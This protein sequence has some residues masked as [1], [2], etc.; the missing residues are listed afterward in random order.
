MLFFY[1]AV[2]GV[3]LEIAAQYPESDY[4]E[5]GMTFFVQNHGESNSFYVIYSDDSEL[6]ELRLTET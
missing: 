3:V 5:R 4:S 2:A 1:F 6:S